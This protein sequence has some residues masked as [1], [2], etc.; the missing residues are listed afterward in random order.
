MDNDPAAFFTSVDQAL[1]AAK[2]GGRNRV[3]AASADTIEASLR[4]FLSAVNA[5]RRLQAV[6]A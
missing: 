2:H 3:Q 1:Y 4:A 5:V 6:A